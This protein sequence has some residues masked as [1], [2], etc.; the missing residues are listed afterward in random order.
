MDIVGRIS[1][2]SKMDQIYIPK[3]RAGLEVGSYVIISPA[4]EKVREKEDKLYFY[5]VKEVSGIKVEIIKRM[6]SLIDSLIKTENIIITGSF[7][8][9][10]FNFSDLDIIIV[11][12]FKRDSYSLAQKL[13]SVLGIN[14]DVL[15]LDNKT[16]SKGL[17]TDPLYQLM[18]S[19]C[20]SRARM[21]HKTK[22][23]IN[24]KLLDLHL[25][26][27]KSFAENFD[28]LDGK[29]KYAHVRNVLS[30]KMFIED[31]KL[32]NEVIEKEIKSVFGCTKSDISGNKLDRISFIEKYKK[33][34]KKLSS[35][36]LEGIKNESKS[37]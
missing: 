32:S 27:S 3:N 17:Q 21:I 12:N 2:G 24:Y 5:G 28:Y 15:L 18:L 7:L 23:E 36:I 8:E 16:L 13:R 25:I 29:E 9:K 6:M 11:S 34:Y 19:R 35:E 33:V 26:K 22:R 20:V 37:K 4:V 30:I 31:R 10:G 14:V 1:K